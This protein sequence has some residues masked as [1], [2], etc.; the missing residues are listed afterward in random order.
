MKRTPRSH[1]RAHRR[2]RQAGLV[3]ACL[4]VDAQA[5][6]TAVTGRVT[7]GTVMRLEAAD[8]NLLTAL[9]APLVGLTGYAS[10]SNADDANLNFRRHDAASTALKAYVDVTAKEGGFVARVRVKGWRDFALEDHDRQWGNVP[11]GY[12]P[13][14]PLSDAGAARL[15]QFSGVALMD[16][17]LQDSVTLMGTRLLGR[18][19]QQSLA[20]GERSGAGGGLDALNARDLP[21]VHRAGAILQETRVP[22]PMLFARFETSATLAIEAFF[23]SSFKPT[24]LDECGTYWAISD[25]LAQGCNAVMSGAPVLNDRARV[26][27]GGVLKRLPTP[28]PAGHD[29]GVAVFWSVA[30]M[31]LGVYQARYT[32]RTPMP[33]L[34]RST[35]VGPPIVPGDPDGRNMAFFTE[36]PEHI[37]ITAMTVARKQGSTTL[38]GEASYRPRAPFMLSPGDVLPPFLSPIVPALLRSDANAVAPGGIFHGYDMHPVAQLQFGVQQ[39][40]HVGYTPVSGTVEV[41]AKHAV[42]LP[43]PS[44]RRYGRPDLFGIGPIFGDCL[45]TTATPAVQC[46]QS[47]YATSDAF[48]YRLRV[49]ARWPALDPSLAASVNALF[50][51]DVKGWSGDFMLNQG[52]RT[53]NLALRVE[54]R[55]RYLAEIAW[56][57]NWG[58]DYNPFSDRDTLALS[59]GIQY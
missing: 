31:E 51:H 5:I 47:G 15:S 4:C 14:A 59:V 10:G 16:A 3:L 54:Y 7:F 46:T 20:W 39:D 18:L 36:Y 53:F 37:D 52:R 11:N 29:A 49:E 48:G 33:S 25:Y 22:Q 9:N 21:A 12:T 27:T 34:R 24:A 40:G 23:A 44:V 32:W 13:G 28:T 55:Q 42:G 35:R 19:G 41:V 17:Y 1:G 8:P 56:Q 57:P 43:D 45:V 30:G 38:F 6:E 26:R 2:S 50:T 58:G